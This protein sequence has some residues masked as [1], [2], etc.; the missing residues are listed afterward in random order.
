MVVEDAAFSS[1]QSDLR[2][3]GRKGAS[4]LRKRAPQ[5]FSAA[6]MW[7]G[8]R[9]TRRPTHGT[10]NGTPPTRMRWPPGEARLV[11]AM[12]VTPG[13]HQG[14]P[15]RAPAACCARANMLPR[16]AQ[17]DSTQHGRARP[18][19]PQRGNLMRSFRHAALGSVSMHGTR[20]RV[21]ARMAPHSVARPCSPPRAP[22]CL[23]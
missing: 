17:R 6:G 15:L 21:H 20:T 4:A 18:A 23:M 12:T 22:G 5:Q 14:S 3:A 8:C 11:R 19:H 1:Q 7:S 16:P 2:I 13:I 10:S 9:F